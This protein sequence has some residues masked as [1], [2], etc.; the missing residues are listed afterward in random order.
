[1]DAVPEDVL[2][3]TG[4]KTPNAIIVT[5]DNSP[6]PNQHANNRSNQIAKPYP[7]KTLAKISS[8]FTTYEHIPS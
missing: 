5:F 4:K 2:M 7:V 3:T 8:D 6:M 1:M